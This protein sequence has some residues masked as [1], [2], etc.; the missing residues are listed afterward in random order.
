MK[1]DEQLYTLMAPRAA[2]IKIE[3]VCLGLRYTAV[4][5]SDGGI[6]LAYTYHEDGEPT[7]ASSAYRDCEG[8]S[9]LVLLGKIKSEEPLKR[10]QALALINA[11][12]YR[13]ALQLPEDRVNR[14]L[15]KTFNMGTGCRIAMVGYFGPL[16]AYLEDCGAVLEIID[17]K[18]GL[19]HKERFYEKLN[20]WAEVLVLTSTSLLNGTTEEILGHVN[21]RVRTVML[22]P[23]TPMVAEAFRH[24]PVHMLA[25]TVPID[26][27]N[28]LKAVRHGM[29]TRV[30]HRFSKKAFWAQDAKLPGPAE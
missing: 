6:G 1:V 10:S 9:A 25:G 2:S 26:K 13:H 22:G 11:L 27:A 12:N 3:Q 5:T 21:P 15:Y 23:S 17:L 30:I 19:G 24:L 18:R 4:T 16:V 7:L 29:G 8:Q 14:I 28:V 20:T